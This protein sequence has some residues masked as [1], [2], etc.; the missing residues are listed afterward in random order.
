MARSI[1]RCKPALIQL[2]CAEPTGERIEIRMASGFPG[3][4][5]RN[6]RGVSP[7]YL[8]ILKALLTNYAGILEGKSPIPSPF[9]AASGLSA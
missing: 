7:N 1:G 6:S 8:A 3:Q 5:L 9:L 4:L 2:F